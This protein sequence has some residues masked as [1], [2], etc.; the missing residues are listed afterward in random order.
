MIQ[1]VWRILVDVRGRDGAAHAIMI[2]DIP[3]EAIR[4]EFVSDDV[5]QELKQIQERASDDVF[6]IINRL[7]AG[8]SEPKP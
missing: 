4:P 6:R 3:S 2:T 5:R 7:H 8:V 1:T